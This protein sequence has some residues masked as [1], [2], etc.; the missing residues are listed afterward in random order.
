MEAYPQIVNIRESRSTSPTVKPIATAVSF[1][2]P[3]QVAFLGKSLMTDWALEGLLV[4]MDSE[5][6]N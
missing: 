3:A 2:M 5:V 4:G 6:V 1:K